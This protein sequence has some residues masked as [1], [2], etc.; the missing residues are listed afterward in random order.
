MRTR[1]I[2]LQ[3]S[4]F[5]VAAMMF[6][7]S[8]NGFAQ[9]TPAGT[10]IKIQASATYSDSGGSNYSSVSN[11]VTFTVARVAGLTITPDGQSG[12]SV[13]PGQTSA[14]FTFRVTNTGN[15][16]DQVRFLANG[17]SIRVTGPATVAE[18]S[19][20]TPTSVIDIH[21]NTANTLHSLDANTSVDISVG[22]DINADALIGSIVQVFLGDAS[23]GTN[24]DNIAADNSANEVSTVSTGAANGSREARGDISATVVSN[25]QIR[26]NLTVPSGPVV[27]GSNITYTVNACNDGG[28]DITPSYIVVPIPVGAQLAAGPFPQG[29][30]FTTDSLNVTPDPPNIFRTWTTTTPGD[31]STVTRIAFPISS[32]TQILLAPGAC[33]ATVSVNLTV[34]ASNA[35][36]P[37]YGIVDA[38]AVR[39]GASTGNNITDQSGDDVTNKGD[40]NANF[41]EPK[42]GE[43]ASATQGFQQ[44]T[45]LMAP[46]DVL[47]GPNGAPTATGPTDTNDD[48][49]NL[50]VDTGIAGVAP[51]GVTTA[52]GTRI[53][54]NTVRNN[55][56]ANDTF[57]LTVPTAPASAT[58]EISTDGGITYTTVS[59][60]GNVN[61]AVA[62]GT[63]SNIN[64]RVTLPAGLN[65][66][67]GYNTVV[68][69]AS[70]ID[71]TKTNETINRVYT[72]FVRFDKSVSIAGGRPIPGA[73]LTHEIKYTNISSIGGNG[74]V[75]LTTT[76][77]VITADGNANPNNWGTTTDHVVGSATDTSNGTITG[78]TA[79]STLLTVT[80]PSLLPGASGTFTFKRKIK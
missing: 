40:G 55:G 29:T 57:T 7:L 62:A 46:P 72:G 71:T 49:T 6:A 61:L 51:G 34:T 65:I 70:Q 27:L 17:G 36:T 56:A 33:S 75:G 80:I 9:Q 30:R 45:G 53:F 24:F 68:R 48:Y 73:E 44:P 18:A 64:V 77:L 1:H 13:V 67:T 25:G 50:S 8:L 37:I 39:A 5:A 21:T 28:V 15:F 12:S 22:L 2:F 43:P 10:E 58:V 19:I 14:D 74:S 31:L 23:S 32:S 66:L 60:G 26:V 54:T 42:I 47:I 35:S 78:D 38:F 63:S 41:D 79:G 11:I 52:T 3:T 4:L 76:N 59:G 16:I 20:I 69:V